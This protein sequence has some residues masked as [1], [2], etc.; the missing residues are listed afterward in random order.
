M[1][2]CVLI[3]QTYSI[4]ATTQHY[5]SQI[6]KQHLPGHSE[7]SIDDILHEQHV[8]ADQSANID[9]VNLH[10]T[11]AARALVRLHADEVKGVWDVLLTI[12]CI[13]LKRAPL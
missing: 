12:V 7:T 13:T 5:Q 11:S 10:I 3:F 9:V 8:L 2:T 6:Y 1:L 4:S